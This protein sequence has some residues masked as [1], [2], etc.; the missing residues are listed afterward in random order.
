MCNNLNNK[1]R[2]TIDFL[3]KQSAQFLGD[4]KI[5]IE[6]EVLSDIRLNA[7]VQSINDDTYRISFFSGCLNLDYAI[8]KITQKYTDDDLLFFKKF[9]K[10]RAFDSLENDTYREELNN[11]FGSM[12]LLHIFYHECGHI[13][14]NHLEKQNKEFLEY[15]STLKGNYEHQEREMVADWLATKYLFSSIYQLVIEDDQPSPKKIISILKHTANLYWLSLSIEFQIFDSNHG[16]EKAD[17]SKLTHP[18]PTVRLYYSIEAMQESM[19]DILNSYGLE[20]SES[21]PL[22]KEIIE[23]F[24]HMIRAFIDI[25]ELPI[26]IEKNNSQV[27]ETYIKL[28]DIPYDESTKKNNY[29]HLMELADE[30]RTANDDIIEFLKNGSL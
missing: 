27:I 14:A 4:S 11:L 16:R 9:E 10:V 3:E 24:Y 2:K 28:R 5:N 7:M 26:D 21:E 20:D 6:I 22:S 12:I 13:A 8:E 15:D 1:Y 30:Y 29:L 18:H 19:M 17:F 25:T 23:E